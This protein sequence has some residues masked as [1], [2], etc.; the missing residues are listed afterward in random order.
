[1]VMIC[2]ATLE[3]EVEIQ[4]KVQLSIGREFGLS[5]PSF[6]EHPAQRQ[7]PCRAQAGQ[8][9]CFQTKVSVALLEA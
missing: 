4:G 3:D 5:A 6:G 9:K 2:K 8:Q 1:M 7:S